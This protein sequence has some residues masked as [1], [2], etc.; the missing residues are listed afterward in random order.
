MPMDK[1]TTLTTLTLTATPTTEGWSLKLSNGASTNLTVTTSGDSIVTDGGGFKSA[2]KKGRE[3]KSIHS[4][5]RLQGGKLTGMTH[6][7]YANGDTATYRTSAT[8]K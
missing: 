8:K 3:V 7:T 2:V 1:D 4:V 6:A 5:Y